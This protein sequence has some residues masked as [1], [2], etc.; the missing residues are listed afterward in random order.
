M[1]DIAVYFALG[2]ASAGLV[3]LAVLP[4]FWR[5]AYRLSQ[6]RIEATLPISPVEIA[7]ERDQLR[8][9]FA[10]ERRRLE[11]RLEAA[12]AGR[13]AEL[14]LSGERLAAIAA[15][16]GEIRERIDAHA[17]LEAVR[18]RL[19]ESL[20]RTE[21]ALGEKT[22]EHDA[23]ALELGRLEQERERQAGELATVTDISN[24][25]RVE[26]AAL[27]TRVEA[28]TADNADLAR[29]LAEAGRDVAGRRQEIAGL[30]RRLHD[31]GLEADRLAFRLSEAVAIGD[32]RA[33]M[34]EERSAETTRL[35]EE[36][37]ALAAR[38]AGAE[39][40]LAALRLRHGEAVAATRDSAAAMDAVRQEALQTARD[41]GQSAMQL[42]AEA[43]RLETE[44]AASVAERARL[45]RELAELRRQV[46]LAG[47]ATPRPA[48]P[49]RPA[50]AAPV[51]ARSGD[52]E[53]REGL[54]SRIRDLQKDLPPV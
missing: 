37:A 31:A 3:L 10:V 33:R 5:R 30:E 6:R 39:E 51:A 14:L 42:R 17:A 40:E 18:A 25:R 46:S 45:T 36:G 44:L 12:E 38:L 29:A 27:S 28:K 49:R 7:A 15:R 34:L 2:F 4:A 11:Q 16:D 20:A 13:H 47:E 8:A 21:A 41:L 32:A 19:A 1:I 23:L 24:Q 26:I 43:T 22:A 52:T 35:A 54:A 50:R 48:N 53:P 9:G